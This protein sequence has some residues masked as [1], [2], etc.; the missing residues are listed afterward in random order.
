M[1]ECV[2]VCVF[3]DGSKMRVRL[4]YG[5][6]FFGVGNVRIYRTPQDSH[7]LFYTLSLS[8]THTTTLTHTQEQTQVE[9]E[10]AAI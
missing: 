10:V 8:H 2:R 7:S 1:R 4:W 5:A 9:R 3:A 6:E